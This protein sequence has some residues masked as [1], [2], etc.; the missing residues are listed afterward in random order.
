M[1]GETAAPE[2]GA[3]AD[4]VHRAVVGRPPPRVPR[5]AFYPYAQGRSTVR[6]REGRLEFRLHDSLRAADMLAV[7]GILALLTCRVRG[8]PESRIDPAAARAYRDHMVRRPAGPMGRGRKH[9][10]PVGTHRSL[11]ES[12]LRVTLDMGLTPPAVPKLLWSKE[13]ARHRLGHWDPDH[14]AVVISQVLDDP[15]VPEF[16]LDYVLYHELLHIIHPVRMGSGSKRV[17][18]SAAFRRDERRFPGW[19][20][21]EKWLA[22]LSRRRA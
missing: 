19:Q 9:I 10:D 12:Y 1:P 14:Q 18:H 5:V 21:A 15:K 20:E 17:V 2:L 11:L 4:A 3:L 6:E 8:V 13:V 22:R 7:E 16:V